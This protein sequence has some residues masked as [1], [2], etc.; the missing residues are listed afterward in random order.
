MATQT[1]MGLV[2][3]GIM[4]VVLGFTLSIGQQIT[5]SNT[6]TICTTGGGGAVWMAFQKANWSTGNGTI[7]NP[8][9]LSFT[10]CCDLRNGTYNLSVCQRW[11]TDSYALNSSYYAMSS[12]NTLA[13]W[14]PI[15]ALATAAGF[16]ISILI[17]YLLGSV[18]GTTKSSI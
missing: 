14:L 9:D 5:A 15:I 17:V 1:L 11:K 18:K 13:Y 16:V 7:G 8:Y 6:E 10:G 2:V 4:F 3:A 12:N